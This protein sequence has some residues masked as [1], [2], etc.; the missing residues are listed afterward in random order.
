MDADDIVV[1]D[2]VLVVGVVLDGLI[3]GLCLDFYT[4]RWMSYGP[5]AH[6]DSLLLKLRE[7]RKLTA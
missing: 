2:P 4:H 5:Q 1:R 6:T 7:G 3:D